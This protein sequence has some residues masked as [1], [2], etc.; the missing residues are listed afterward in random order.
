[1][2]TGGT[3]DC[4]R[5]G[6]TKTAVD[7]NKAIAANSRRFSITT[8]ATTPSTDIYTERA[9]H[10]CFTVL[11]TTSGAVYAGDTSPPLAVAAR[12]RLL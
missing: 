10:Q 9:R 4:R 7:M 6:V 3:G 11:I 8:P 5:L 1:M 2:T 12:F